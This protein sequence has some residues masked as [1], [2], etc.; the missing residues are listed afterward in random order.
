LEAANDLVKDNLYV[1]SA[2]EP[3]NSDVAD[4]AI[5]R[6]A[7]AA[8]AP[9]FPAA[10]VAADGILPRGWAA[11]RLFERAVLLAHGSLKAPDLIAA[12][13][14]MKGETLAGLLPPQTYGPG[15]HP[16]GRCGKVLRWNGARWQVITPEFVC[17]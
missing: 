11:G 15:V 12:L 7:M 16:E 14:S 9:N 4:V 10:R 17:G 5:L 13:R 3:P 2:L 6:Q 8:Y 1:G